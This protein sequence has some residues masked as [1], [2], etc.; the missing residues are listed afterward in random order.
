MNY[1]GSQFGQYRLMR[2]IGRGGFADVYE[3]WDIHLARVVAVKVLRGQL[4]QQFLREARLLARLDHPHIV[5][6]V[7]FNIHNN[8]PYCVMA[9]AQGSLDQ[10]HPS[11]EIL[12]LE[13]VIQYIWQIAD[14]LT[15]L[16]NQGF[17][18][19]DVKPGNLLLGKEG[20]I[21][22]A[23]FGIAALIQN[24]EPQN[25]RAIVGTVAYMAP[26][27]F[28]GD[29]YTASDQYALAVI[30]YEWLTGEAL[31]HGSTKEVIW[32]HLHSPVPL[33]RMRNLGVPH[34][35]RQ[36]LLKALAKQP[37]DRFETVHAF[38][39]ALE[40][41]GRDKPESALEKTV[42][43]LGIALLTSIVSGLVPYLVGA[44]VDAVLFV[45]SL[46]GLFASLL[47]ALVRDNRFVLRILLIGSL[48][49]MVFALI[50]HSWTV[51]Y[52]ILLLITPICSFLGLGVSFA[53]WLRIR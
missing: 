34:S 50:I 49:A 4:P 26:E 40:Q 12:L 2:R 21:L 52:L 28:R 30:V 14:A 48:A 47:S 32:Q 17:V 51:F 20:E 7:E 41:A 45:A 53:K 1:S 42:P 9:Y 25:G 36:V 44:G 31:F 35:I 37:E 6:V 38:A 22:L 18:H 33:S 11:G 27:R 39:Q 24:T 19:L 10:R 43:I 8:I 5:R 23:D 3:A 29:A 46:S 15:Y 16:H 13:L